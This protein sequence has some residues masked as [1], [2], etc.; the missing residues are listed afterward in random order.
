MIIEIVMGLCAKTIMKKAKMVGIDIFIAFGSGTASG[1]LAGVAV[2]LLVDHWYRPMI[3][4]ED[5]DIP[6]KIDLTQDDGSTVRFVA[7]RVVVRNHGKSAAECCKAYIE[8]SRN[9]IERAAWMI[10][11]DNDYTITLNVHDIEYVDL[12]A[13]TEDGLS[14][15]L[16]NSYVIDD[17]WL[18]DLD[19]LCFSATNLIA[20]STTVALVSS[21]S[22]IE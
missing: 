16:L 13:I 12:Y 21:S 4:I 6:R 22:F 3:R 19:R 17:D 10:P 5:D 14:P 15:S 20:S 9:E 8:T 7:H 1:I 2:K 18:L 11:H